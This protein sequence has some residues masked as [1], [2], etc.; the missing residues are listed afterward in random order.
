MKILM[1]A[2][3]SSPIVQ[4][5]SKALEKN[6]GC[7]VWVASFN[8][9]TDLEKRIISLGE[10]NSFIDYF[11][12]YK[13]NKLVKK[14][15]PDIVHAHIINHYGIMAI[16]QK[17]PLIVGLWGSDVMLAPNKGS[18]LK[19]KIFKLINAIVI[20]RA[21][22]M[23]TSSN[24]I[25]EE[26]VKKHGKFI[27][28]KINV[29]Y[30]GFPVEEPLGDNYQLIQAMLKNEYGIESNDHLIVFPRGL[31]K[32]YDPDNVVK[33]IKKLSD[34]KELKIVVLRGFSSDEDIEKFKNKLG[35]AES[36]IIFINRLLN[37]NE[38][39]VLYSQA[40]YHVSLPISDA[41]GGGVIEPF[42]RGSFPI[43]SNIKPYKNFVEQNSGFIL[44]DYSEPSLNNLEQKILNNQLEV[45]GLSLNSDYSTQ[46]IID[47][48]KKL[49]E[50]VLK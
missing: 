7:E 29:F 46:A 38:L 2:P 21:N 30:W 25:L 48:F 14:L 4:R 49:Y 31:S 23:H 1:L 10:V 15:D 33:V 43:L 45:E 6:G 13:V 18:L 24:H 47:K 35:A 42:L 17:K 50:I 8:V 19:R 26:L 39:F 34:I 41:L 27:K 40:K 36:K 20:K 3:Y 28:N 16:F 9:E 12:F 5:L 44:E 37:T 32:V 22:L 11:K